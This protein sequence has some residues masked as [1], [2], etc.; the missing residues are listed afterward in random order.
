[1]G[2]IGK[3]TISA[4]YESFDALLLILGKGKY[5]TSG[6]VFEYAATG[7]PIASIH[8][9]GNAATQVLEGSPVWVATPDL[10]AN[11]VASTLIACANMAVKQTSKDKASAQSWAKQFE[12]STQLLPRID[13]LR[14][15]A[16]RA[17]ASQ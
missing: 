10:S 3:A 6:K 2:P 12:R 14:P 5:V 1:L 16:A 4:T 11:A 15:I 9:P 8:D 13:A 7:L 17:G